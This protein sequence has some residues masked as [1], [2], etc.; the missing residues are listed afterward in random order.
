MLSNGSAS[1]ALNPSLGPFRLRL[2]RPPLRSGSLLALTF[3]TASPTQPTAPGF[4]PVLRLSARTTL[5]RV[6]TSDST[7]PNLKTLLADAAAI[8][9]RWGQVRFTPPASK[10]SPELEA[11]VWVGGDRTLGAGDWLQLELRFG[12]AV[13][14]LPGQ[15]LRVDLGGGEMRELPLLGG[16]GSCCLR[17]GYRIAAG[18]QASA[19]RL[20]PT[21]FAERLQPF[22]A[23][24][25]SLSGLLATAQDATAPVQVIAAL[26]DP[27]APVQARVT[28]WQN[29][30]LQ[31]VAKEAFHPLLASRGLALLN[32]ALFDAVNASSGSPYLGYL[33]RQ[34]LARVSDANLSRLID[35]V[36][37]GV[38]NGIF[39]GKDFISR[40]QAAE[41]QAFRG[42]SPLPSASQ[43]R[44]LGQSVANAFLDSRAGDFA[45]AAVA[46][47]PYLQTYQQQS[48]PGDWQRTPSADAA[49]LQPGW[50]RLQPWLLP[51]VT[52][53]RP[54]GFTPITNTAIP[55][56]PSLDSADYAAAL[57]EVQQ[58]GA[59]TD[60]L[61]TAEQ[62]AIATFWANG[63][64]TF[65]PP[66]HWQT[67]QTT[68]A[69]QQSLGLLSSLRLHAL[70]S[71]A[72]A[73]AAIAAWA[74]K[75]DTNL[76]RPVTAIRAADSDGNA[77]TTADPNWTP[78]IATPPFPTLPSGH[79]TFSGA[80]ATVLAGLIGDQQSFT[81]ILQPDPSVQR[82]FDSLWQAA[83]ESGRSRIFGGIHFEF[84]NTIGL[85][86]GQA[87]G[88]W[89]LALGAMPQVWLND[90]D[91]SYNSGGA[92]L[93][94]AV[95]GGAGNARIQ[96]GFTNLG[97]QFWGDAGN[98]ELIAGGLADRLWGG[99]GSDRLRA[100]GGACLLVGSVGLEEGEVDE[101]I[102]GVG[103]DTFVLSAQN[104]EGV[105]YTTATSHAVIRDYELDRDR[106]QLSSDLSDYRLATGTLDLGGYSLRGAWFSAG[107]AQDRLAFLEASGSA[108]ITAASLVV[109]WSG[110]AQ[111]IV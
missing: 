3:A 94:R 43:A 50:G 35:A 44:Q 95:H 20:D 92:N 83:L 91:D 79:S 52:L 109:T 78:L 103:V 34:P 36:G 46:S 38:L 76:W 80:A 111:M 11:I 108:S 75:Y 12:D 89:A 21:S 68:L 61:R 23:S 29:L 105:A 82:S 31:G 5:Y 37:A 15:T 60:S 106:L 110:V 33:I 2:A 27:E 13:R 87:V 42:F 48:D 7:T 39:A 107:P 54:G 77:A 41:A 100:G 6:V 73:D 104:A 59:K 74:E 55:T 99:G 56:A 4:D 57:L 81:S 24:G 51:S 8:D 58:L 10:A 16:S 28:F 72:L 22:V 66:G 98:D 49:P 86:M 88:E 90:D 45:T 47:A 93:A 19:V 63:G 32:G 25:S 96:A 102:G 67:I 84:D 69:Q 1:P 101:L 97:H 64:G 53:A 65:T 9:P 40:V 85:G 71:Y 18:D 14:L 70:S 30:L 26:A 62:T 17:F